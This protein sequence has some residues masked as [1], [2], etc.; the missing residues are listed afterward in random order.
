MKTIH[1]IDEIN[2]VHLV[3]K[4]GQRVFTKEMPSGDQITTFTVIVPRSTKPRIGNQKVDSLA[5]QT[6]KATI[7]SKVESWPVGT[8]VEI[9]GELR[10]RFWQS[11]NGPGSAT[12][13]EVRSMVRVRESTGV[14]R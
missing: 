1:N 4:L 12:E 5:C 7:R 6:L 10:R 13:I 14:N 8:W 11:G 3:G 2:N 9:H